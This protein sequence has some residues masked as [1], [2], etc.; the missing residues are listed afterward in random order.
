MAANLSAVIQTAL[1][2]PPADAWS[3]L[4]GFVAFGSTLAAS[5]FTQGRILG[6][7]T[8]SRFPM[9]FCAGLASVCAASLASHHASIAAHEYVTYGRKPRAL[10]APWDYQSN[11]LFSFREDHLDLKIV[12]IPLHTVRMYVPVL[13][14]HH[15]CR[16]FT[17]VY[18]SLC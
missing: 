17:A 5:T 8:G 2:Q 3:I 18:F 6:I 1:E 7:S 4:A 11:A 9:P 13:H 16:P 15:W 10:F 14:M 12:Q